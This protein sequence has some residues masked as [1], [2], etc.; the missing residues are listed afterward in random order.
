MKKLQAFGEGWREISQHGNFRHIFF[1]KFLQIS[2]S[3]QLAYKKLIK[4]EKISKD[5]LPKDFNLVLSNFKKFGN[6]FDTD[7]IFWWHDVGHKIFEKTDNKKLA[8]NVDI[9]LSKDELIRQFTELVDHIKIQHD[10]TKNDGIKLL[11]NKITAHSLHL[12]H[13]LVDAKAEFFLNKIKKEQN[14]TLALFCN[15]SKK[16]K[17]FSQEDLEQ[18]PDSEDNKIYLNILA[19][20]TLKEAYW[21]AENAARG[22]FP[23][24]DKIDTGL[25]FDYRFLNKFYANFYKNLWSTMLDAERNGH[26]FMKFVDP[27]NL[28]KVKKKKSN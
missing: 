27:V 11:N 8:I 17:D 12:R 14:W 7:Y 21:I 18:T 26:D 4:K 24:L 1:Y 23:S 15:L 28:G 6:V 13:Y 22:K 25:A 10:L 2:P 3:Y 9:S 5:L 16:F 20:K 19:S